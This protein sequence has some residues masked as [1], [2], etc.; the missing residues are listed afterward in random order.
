MADG[1]GG[2]VADSHWDAVRRRYHRVADLIHR[3]D[4]PDAAD[5]RG[6]RPEID[7]LAADIDVAVVERLQ[8]LRQG[9]PLRQQTI[10]IDGDLV[11]L[12]LAAPPGDVDDPGHRLEPALEYPILDG[13]EIGDA[14]A[15]GAHDA[16]TIDLADRAFRRDLRSDAVG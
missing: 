7:G 3:V 13:L 5:D 12:G 8:H 15:R 1:D 4:Q 2:H 6:L 14:E 10:E 9:D 16:I 11:G